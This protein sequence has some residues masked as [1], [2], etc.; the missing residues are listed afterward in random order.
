MS[1]TSFGTNKHKRCRTLLNQQSS[2]R[3]TGGELETSYAGGI[4]GPAR[5]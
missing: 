5:D 2:N 3:K 1:E 4:D